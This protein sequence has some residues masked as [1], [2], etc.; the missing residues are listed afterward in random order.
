M[1]GV[2]VVAGGQAPHHLVMLDMTL[3]LPII[4]LNQALNSAPN[5]NELKCSQEFLPHSCEY[6]TAYRDILWS[7]RSDKQYISLPKYSTR[8][9]IGKL[10]VWPMK[11]D[12][13]GLLTLP[14]QP[15]EYTKPLHLEQP[16]QEWHIHFNRVCAT[17]DLSLSGFVAEIVAGLKQ[18]QVF[19]YKPHSWLPALRVEAAKDALPNPHRLSTILPGLQ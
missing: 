7:R 17:G 1:L 13:R 3:T 8:R 5:V 4:Y 12:D 9:E 6:L 16:E 15:G 10:A 11:H 18:V 14:L 19:Y 2:R